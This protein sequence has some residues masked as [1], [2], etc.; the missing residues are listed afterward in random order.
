MPTMITWKRVR[1]RDCLGSFRGQGILA[2]ELS[3]KLDPEGTLN[4][5]SI[6]RQ[7]EHQNSRE[8]NQDSL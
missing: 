7:P 4:K 8:A 1:E 3:K 5:A 2:R 6:K